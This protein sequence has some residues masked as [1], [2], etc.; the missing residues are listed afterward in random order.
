MLDHALVL[1]FSQPHSFTGQ[2]LVELQCHGSRAVVQGLLQTLPEVG[3]RMAEPGEFTQRAFGNGKL[4]LVQVEALADVLTADTNAQLQQALEQAQQEA[5]AGHDQKT[6]WARAN[7]VEHRIDPGK[8]EF[9][10]Y[11]MATIGAWHLYGRC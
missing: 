6:S 3:C 2:D 10:Q 9:H 7:L 11:A 5:Q 4:D 1:L 8:D